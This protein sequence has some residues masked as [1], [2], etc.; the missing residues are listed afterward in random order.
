MRAGATMFEEQSAAVLNGARVQTRTRELD[1]HPHEPSPRGLSTRHFRAVGTPRND[2]RLVPLSRGRTVDH[3][4]VTCAGPAHGLN[5]ADVARAA[6]PRLPTHPSFSPSQ[7][8][9]AHPR[10]GW[11][12]AGSEARL[13]GIARTCP[14]SSRLHHAG[15]R[16]AVHL[17]AHPAHAHAHA[18]GREPLSLSARR[19]A[20]WRSLPRHL[21]RRRARASRSARFTAREALRSP[22][23]PSRTK[24][25]R[26]PR[27]RSMVTARTLSSSTPGPRDRS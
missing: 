21:M 18:H 8:T 1:A 11:T 10:R 5:G 17:L 15:R 27:C 23:R 13:G 4:H 24:P 2:A 26:L 3:P 19:S 20:R 16:P 7:R 25:S 12:R 14:Q 9:H 6:G 22:S